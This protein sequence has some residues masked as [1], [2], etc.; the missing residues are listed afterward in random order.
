M[1]TPY[2]NT[3]FA[4]TTDKNTHPDHYKNTD[5]NHDPDSQTFNEDE[6]SWKNKQGNQGTPGNNWDANNPVERSNEKKYDEEQ[7]D[8]TDYI[9]SDHSDYN[10][11]NSRFGWYDS[12]E[13]F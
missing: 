7:R 13:N 12:E 9:N 5:K 2:N 10:R 4:G 1:N 8:A 6:E 3:L 11:G